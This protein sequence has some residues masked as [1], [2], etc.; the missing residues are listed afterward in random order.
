M[1]KA[2]LDANRQNSKRSTGPRTERGKRI[3]RFNAVTLGLFAKHIVIPICDGYRSE[4]EVQSLLDGLHQEFQPAGIFE[5]WLVVKIAECMW[6]LRLSCVPCEIASSL[7]HTCC[8]NR[9][10]C[11]DGLAAGIQRYFP[12]DHSPQFWSD[13]GPLHWKLCRPDSLPKA[14][15]ERRRIEGSAGAAAKYCRNCN[16]CGSDQWPQAK[17]ASDHV[18][19][20]ACRNNELALGKTA[21]AGI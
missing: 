21:A 7:S 1:T 20:C 4:K 5:E 3:A 15:P 19:A 8:C 16:L 13:R 12:L 11:V 2:K 14:A 18:C 10:V 9:A 17:R 6:R